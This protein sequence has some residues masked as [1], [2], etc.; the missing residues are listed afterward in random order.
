MN[1][2]QNIAVFEDGTEFR[3]VPRRYESADEAW[4]L[5]CCLVWDKAR[6]KGHKTAKIGRVPYAGTPAALSFLRNCVVPEPPEG[7]T[8]WTMLNAPS[9]P[10]S[11]S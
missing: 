9:V 10:A 11:E 8:S 1:R 3:K 2:G 5:F 4:G 7:H 6:A